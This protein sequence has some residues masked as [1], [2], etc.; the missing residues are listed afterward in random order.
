M[1]ARLSSALD[2]LP[3]RSAAIDAV[4]LLGVVAIVAGHVWTRPVTA[5]WFYP[6][7]VP[8]F[9]IISGYLWKE[10]RSVRQEFRGRLS[11][12]GRPY[13]AWLVLLT[14]ALVMMGTVSNE[15]VGGR[16]LG[17]I[18]GGAFAV[19]PYTTL[20]FVSA[21]FFTAVLYRAIE[22]WPGWLQWLI[23]L[24]GVAA[25]V[26][27]GVELA[28]FPLGIGYAISCLIYILI[29]RAFRT[30][31]SRIGRSLAWGGGLAYRRSRAR[32]HGAIFAA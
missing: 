5:E 23:G 24:G 31:R 16:I 19:L 9:L 6:W 14:V 8:V 12:L 17:G 27:W 13:V 28:Y 26:L 7:H 21:L 11:S 29:G 3:A 32:C 1:K 20:W 2:Q 18:L 10:G 22:Q 15:P 4:R 25:G 30:L